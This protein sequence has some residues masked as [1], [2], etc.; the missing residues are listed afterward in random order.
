MVR[1]TREKVIDTFGHGLWSVHVDLEALNR[2]VLVAIVVFVAALY[3]ALVWAGFSDLVRRIARK[4]NGRKRTRN[5]GAPGRS[6]RGKG[7]IRQ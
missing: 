4:E 1:E 5:R 7:S 2:F 3:I 6:A